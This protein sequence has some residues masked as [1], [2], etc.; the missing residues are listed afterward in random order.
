MSK[1]KVD[2]ALVE[3]PISPQL[4]KIALVSSEKK[5]KKKLSENEKTSDPAKGP[6]CDVLTKSLRFE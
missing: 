2:S 6:P 5:R 4:K 3:R 1:K